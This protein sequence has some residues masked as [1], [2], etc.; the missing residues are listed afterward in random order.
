[1]TQTQEP[2]TERR[3][4]ELICI[5]LGRASYAYALDVQRQLL[6]QVQ[7]DARQAY[8]VL[9]EHDPPVITLGRRARHEH[10][11]ASPERLRELGVEVHI[12]PRGGDVTWHGVG[13]VVAYPIVR[14]SPRGRTVHGHVRALE[15]AAIGVLDSYGLRAERRAGFP[16]AWVGQ[17]KVA[18]VGVAVSRWVAW[19]G[20]ALNVSRNLPGFELIVPCGLEGAGPESLSSLLGRDVP[21]A[22]VRPRLALALC[23]A[24]GFDNSTPADSRTDGIEI[25]ASP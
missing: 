21:A 6:A 9:V 1:M 25:D 14:L 15:E 16:G 8:L 13:Q 22:E 12:S 18:A 19:H 17:N 7:E 3:A 10:V 4:K 20:L 2:I 24:L 11:L 5:D 23:V